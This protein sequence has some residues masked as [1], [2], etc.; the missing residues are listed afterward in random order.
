M[1]AGLCSHLSTVFAYVT[2]LWWNPIFLVPI[3]PILSEVCVTTADY[4]FLLKALLSKSSVTPPPAGFPQTFPPGTPSSCPS[5]KYLQCL[6][7]FFS[8]RTVFK[9]PLFSKEWP[10]CKKQK[11]NL[12]YLCPKRW[13]INY[14]QDPRKRW[15]I[16]YNQGSKT[17]G[18]QEWLDL[19]LENYP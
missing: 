2:S 8:P 9:M 17:A 16:R 11:F 3:L 14:S 6:S 18:H 7:F 13:G 19:E 15:I 12:N 4:A 1:L 10:V 5:L